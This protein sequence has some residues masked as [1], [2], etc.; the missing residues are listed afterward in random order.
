MPV[1]TISFELVPPPLIGLTVN[2]LP[3]HIDDGITLAIIGVGFTVTVRVNGD[4]TQFPAAPE[5]GVT[6]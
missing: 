3:E 1:G 6:V 2:K 5:A 4:P